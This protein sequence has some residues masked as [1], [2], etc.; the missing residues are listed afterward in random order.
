MQPQRDSCQS[1][2]LCLS[3]L[4]QDEKSSLQQVVHTLQAQLD[5]TKALLYQTRTHRDPTRTQ[6]DQ[7]TAVL[8]DPEEVQSRAEELDE[9]KYRYCIT[10]IEI[11]A[12]NKC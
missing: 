11:S 8:L 7:I 9:H 12:V 5:Q 2:S 1:C 10:M 3:V 6:M 4:L